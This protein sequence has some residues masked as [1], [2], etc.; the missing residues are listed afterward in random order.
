MAIP[1]RSNGVESTVRTPT[2]IPRVLAPGNS[3]SAARRSCTWIVCRSAIARLAGVSRSMTK[4]SPT[5][6]AMGNRAKV[7]NKT[8]KITIDAKD[9]SILR[10]TQLRGSLGN[11]IEHGLEVRRRASDHPEDVAGGSLAFE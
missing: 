1:S 8:Q 11:R 4:L 3:V 5:A 2:A 10:V 6:S 7:R 9:G